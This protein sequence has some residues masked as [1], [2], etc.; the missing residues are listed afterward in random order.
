M[1]EKKEWSRPEL[2]THGDVEYLTQVKHLN[3]SDGIGTGSEG[4]GIRDFEIIE[5]STFPNS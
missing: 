4:E 5:V 2:T 3:T 1:I